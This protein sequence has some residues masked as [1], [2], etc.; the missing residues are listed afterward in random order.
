MMKLNILSLPSA[1]VLHCCKSVVTLVAPKPLPKVKFRYG[2]IEFDFLHTVLLPVI[3][4][5]LFCFSITV[6]ADTVTVESG[7]SAAWFNPQ[8]DG[9]GWVLEILD[10]ERAL[11]FWYTYNEQGKQRWLISVGNIVQDTDGEYI[12]FPELLVAQGGRFGPEFDPDSVELEV[13][14]KASLRFVDCNR[15]AFSYHAFDQSQVIEIQRLTRTMA[16]GCAPINGVPGLPVREYAGQSGSWYDLAHDG[17]GFSLQWMSRDQAVLYWFSYD[18]E[19]NQYWMFGVGEYQNA[20]IIFPQVYSTQGARFGP[21]FDPKDVELIDWGSLALKLECRTGS[22]SYTSNIPEFGSGSQA[23]TRLTTLQQPKCP[24]VQP[25][26]TDLYEFTWT[27]IPIPPS[28]SELLTSI[29][30]QSIADDGTI[31]AHGKLGVVIWRPGSTEWQPLTE[32][33][34]DAAAPALISPDAGSIIVNERRVTDPNISNSPII[35]RNKTEWER[36]SNL[37]LHKSFLQGASEDRSVLL[38][39]GK[40]LGEVEQ[41]SWIWD[42]ADGQ[43]LLPQTT[44]ISLTTPRTASNDGSIVV[45]DFLRPI[46]DSV[47]FNT[48]GIRW[49][50]GNDP[51]ILQDSLGID[52][53]VA[54]ACNA[55]CSI[56]VGTN[57]AENFPDHPNLGQAWFWNQERG[58]GYFGQ[59][60]GVGNTGDFWSYTP[61]DITADGS[62]V[63]GRYVIEKDNDQLENGAFIWTQATGLVSVL[64]LIEEAGLSEYGWGDMNAFGVTSLGDKILLASKW[65][66]QSLQRR[67]AILGLTEKED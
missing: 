30:V 31:V 15:G 18:S 9:E 45:G 29:R 53:G 21:D 49:A 44:E 63:V 2:R 38:G 25:K 54:S 4:L 41:F 59:L 43:R 66:S 34:T 42:A 67:V 52:L 11:V 5:S 16:A 61:L 62:L 32:V 47:F 27:E 48:V 20:E 36:L 14:G 37:V 7:H 6:A 17:E 8:R 26:L 1:V 19:G 51:E 65:D 3:F 39:T 23:L 12:E 46:E 64:E 35:W 10:D 33:L 40:H 60:P 24:W 13:I 22:V 50:H 28:N 55:D 56:I 57:Q 58:S